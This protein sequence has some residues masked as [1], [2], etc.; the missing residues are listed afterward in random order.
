MLLLSG[1]DNLLL[2]SLSGDKMISM[3]NRRK[4]FTLIELLIVIAI[5]GI[6]SSLVIARFSNVRENARIANTLQWSSGVHRT[7]GANLVGH[8]PLDGDLNDISGYDNHGTW[9]GT[10]SPVYTSGP[11]GDINALVVT[12]DDDGVLIP[13]SMDNTNFGS[14][15]AQYTF[16]TWIYLSDHKGSG[17]SII[18]GAAYYGGFGLF[19]ASNGSTYTNANTYFRIAEGEIQR[20]YHTN[21]FSLELNKWYNLVSILDRP[22]SKISFYADGVLI[23]QNNIGVGSFCRDT[24]NFKINGINAPGGNDPWINISGLFSDV[25]IYDTALTTEEVGR[26]YA[27]TKDK[28]LVYE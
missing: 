18:L 14:S 10:S 24:N 3:R 6:L 28:Y 15:N 4:S 1:M 20:Q 5:I 21:N 8:W 7:L 22:N 12:Q 26:I 19:I 25:R 16:S 11:V 17:A 27:E 13:I 9:S 2:F 23:S